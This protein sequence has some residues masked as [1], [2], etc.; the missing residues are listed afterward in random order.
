MVPILDILLIILIVVAIAVLVYFVFFLNKLGSNIELMA[1]DAHELK[2]RT[3]LLLIQL[4]ETTA[5]ANSI[6]DK[7]E[8]HLNSLEEFIDN[9][10]S[11]YKAFS[12]G[13]RT[14]NPFA[15]FIKNISA[16][17]KGINAFW[18]KYKD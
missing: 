5:K 9:V 14:D 13:V 8:S 4:E 3:E 2:Q 11:R 12:D 17:S 6:V 18:K 10:Q 1:R 15:D 7:A 16:V